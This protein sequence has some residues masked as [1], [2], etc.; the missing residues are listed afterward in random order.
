MKLQSMIK[1]LAFAGAV[2]FATGALA[3]GGPRGSLKDPPRAAPLNW[4]GF[5]VGA[6][7]GYSAAD[8]DW[9][10]DYPFATPQSFVSRFNSEK[11][12]TGAHI[13]L[14]Q[15]FGNWVVGGELSL[16]GGFRSS[17]IN[18]V[19]LFAP[20]VGVLQTQIGSLVTATARVG[21]S[22]DQWL[23]YVK[24]GFAGAHV[25]LSA[26]DNVPPDFGFQTRNFHSGWTVGAGVERMFI[27]GVILGLEYNYVD[28]GQNRSD[29]VVVLATGAPL[30]GAFAT[31]NVDTTIHSVMA[32]LS[33]KLGQP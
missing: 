32:R 24:G 27:S 21:Y 2:A 4:T 3:D 17:T 8:L 11:L 15:Q 23:G 16:S 13:G 9:G 7:A 30:A 12:I 31:S 25:R 1:A 28:L 6:H 26:D 20:G 14:Q 19:D 10:L 5:Y 33:I 29:Q 22:W 18:G